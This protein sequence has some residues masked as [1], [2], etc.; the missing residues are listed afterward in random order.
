MKKLLIVIV[1]LVVLIGG[2]F[3]YA[4]MNANSLV[5]TFKP[6]IEKGASEALGAAVT[7]GNIDV[8]VFPTT[9]LIVDSFEVAET[10]GS[11]DTLK[12][13]NLTF[14]ANLM[15]LL[16]G[17][18][19]IEELSLD[20]PS[21]TFIKDA[22]GVSV[23]GLPKPKQANTQKP[24]AKKKKEEKNAASSTSAMSPPPGALSLESFA[25]K[26]GT[27]VYVDKA[28]GST[29]T[30]EKVN[31]ESGLLFTDGILS[32][33]RLD[34]S[35]SIK[36]K[37][38]VGAQGKGFS[39]DLTTGKAKLSDLTVSALG[40]KTTLSGTLYTATLSG[41]LDVRAGEAHLGEETLTFSA[42]AALSKGT[43]ALKKL[44]AQAFGGTIS[45]DASYNFQ[46]TQAFT[47]GLDIAELDLKRALLAAKP[48]SPVFLI[49]TLKG[50]KGKIQGILGN[51]LKQSLTGSSSIDI[52]DAELKG[53]NL[54]GAVLQSVKNLPFLSDSLYSAVPEEERAKLQTDNTEIE[55]LTGNI[56]IN[57]ETLQTNDLFLVS[58][59]FDLTAKG[60]I[61]F[62]TSLN[63]GAN[64]R[65]TELFSLSLAEKIS[66]LEDWLDKDNRLN[67][68]LRIKGTA[69]KVVV[70]PDVTEL[71]KSNAGKALTNKLLGKVFGNKED[72][73]GQGETKKKGGGLGGLLGGF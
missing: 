64:I 35:A 67:I 65:F 49:G 34:A 44:T 43:A 13:N 14:R 51:S 5:A 38:S 66:E 2:V 40:N 26:N 30:I 56:S 17:K 48:D 54:A 4:L 18:L 60:T 24:K 62:D 45:S 36:G 59:I 25:L 57:S 33:P 29:T 9:K 55:S 69:A 11:K 68:P 32:L 3:A 73:E 42:D 1:I 21:I 15:S 50:A 52:K 22:A 12:L 47:A 71:L 39:F 70:V 16:S 63:L 37:G 6:D 41:N 53:T 27:F 8:S 10:K 46:K 72:K 61:G 28:S 19:T 23:Q 31:L 7:L 58:T 20:S